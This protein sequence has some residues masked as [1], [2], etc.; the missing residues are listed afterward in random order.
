M[1]AESWRKLEGLGMMC[2]YNCKDPETVEHVVDV[3]GQE[4]QGHKF[5]GIKAYETG[6]SL[7]LPY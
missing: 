4:V 7:V 3:G 5:L 6:G 1:N 2:H